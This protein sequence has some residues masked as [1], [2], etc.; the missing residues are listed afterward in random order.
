Q[1]ADDFTEAQGDDGQVVAAQ[2][3]HRKA[4]Q[5]AEQCCHGT[6]DGQRGPEAEPVVMGEQRVGIGTHRVE[7]DVAQIQQAGQADDDVQAQAQHHVDQD[8]RG[9]VHRAARGIERPDQRHQH[10]RN[11][12]VALGRG[13]GQEVAGAGRHGGQTWAGRPAGGQTRAEQLPDE[14][15]HGAGGDDP[16]SRGVGAMY[17]DV[18][19]DRG[20]LQAKY[21][22]RHCDDQQGAEEGCAQ[23]A[24]HTFS[25]SGRPRMPVG[26]NSNTRISRVN[27]TT[28]LYWSPKIS[29]PKASATPSTRAPSM[30][31]G[32]LPMP[33]SSAAVTALM[34]ARKPMCG[35]MAAYCMLIS[36]AAIA[37][38]AAPM[39]KVREMMLLVLM[40]SRLAIFRS[41]AQARQARPRRE[42]EMNSVRPII[43]TMVT[44][45]ISTC[46]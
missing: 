40:P 25:T 14:H 2:A 39:T 43:A 1:Q 33:P 16:E 5:E 6:G 42:R 21:R 28:S 30:A 31:P 4:Q 9:N 8:Q 19:A 20:E 46:I 45:K 13:Q 23:I 38:S 24:S 18:D 15:G 41:S 10:Q 11:D 35:L 44:T 7:A 27:A 34:P 36:T 12:D 17:L 22:N 32:M 26:R 3:Q 29:A 37:A